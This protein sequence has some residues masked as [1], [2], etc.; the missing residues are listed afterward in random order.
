MTT[1]NASI[2]VGALKASAGGA[3]PHHRRVPHELPVALVYDGTTYAVMMASPSD[4]EDFAL[5]FSLAEGIVAS[6][7]QIKNLDVLEHDNGIELRMWL[8]PDRGRNLV[9]RRR[10]LAGP[11]G[12]GLCGVESLDAAVPAC[13]RVTAELTVDAQDI[14][15]ALS[16]LPAAQSLNQLTRAVHGAGF[17][18]G[19]D[20]LVALA[21]DVGRHNALDKLV[22][23]LR[24]SG[25]N[26]GTGIVLL[27][28]RVSVEMVQ[29]A[30][31]AGAPIIAAISAPTALAVRTAEQA[32]ITLA[33]IA[34]ADGFEIFTHPGRI[35]GLLPVQNLSK[36]MVEHAA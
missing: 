6:P 5:G 14:A 30:A 15:A 24:R 8:S 2:E 1:D 18:T 33:A 4:L 12:C 21:E 16:S 13:P 11:T 20:G 36:R 26:I 27:T 23:R 19:K 7:E 31:A 32:G 22:G 17:W 3:A 28:S 35:S 34:R 10:R 9:E 25:A 29:K